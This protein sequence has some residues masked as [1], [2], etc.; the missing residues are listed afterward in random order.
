MSGGPDVERFLAVGSDDDHRHGYDGSYGYGGGDGSGDGY[1]PGDGDG[2][3]Y[4][5]GY[6]DDDG[7]GDSFGDCYGG[8]EEDGKGWGA[9]D[10]YG[11]GHGLKSFNGKTVHYI[12]DL[13][14]ILS[15]VVG[16]YARGYIILAD[17]TLK[18]TFIARAGDC[19]AHGETLH[20]AQ[21]EAT[22][23]DMEDR[24]LEER[25]AMFKTVFPDPDVECRGE[26]LFA[27]HG[28]LTGSCKQGRLA[29]CRDHQLDPRTAR[30]T[31]REFCALTRDAY[32][33][34][35]IRELERLYAGRNG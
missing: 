20:E 7:S 6:G 28:T 23:K 10:N 31:V 35:A 13:P 24:P 11:N 29:W 2:G 8:G 3:G 5:S 34:E 1:G 25:L 30:M 21:A 26:D 17:M 27:W 33:G 15:H 12:D 9:G 18:P 4:G 22:R 32:G 19:F 14:T 16:V